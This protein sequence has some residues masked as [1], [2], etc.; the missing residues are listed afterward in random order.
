MDPDTVTL[1]ELW[2]ALKAGEA[3]TIPHHTLK[4]PEPIDWST[5]HNSEFQRNIEIYSGHGLSE[6][7]DPTHPLA[8]EQSLFTNP[9]QTTKTGMSA[10]RAWIQGHELSTIAS[11]DDHRAHPGQPQYGLAAIRSRA[12]TREAIFNGLYKRQ[13]Y[14]TTGARILLDF[15]INNVLMGNHTAVTKRASIH[16]RAVGTDI[17][18]GIEVLRHS[19]NQPGFQIIHQASPAEEVVTLDSDD[20]PPIGSA[21]YYVRL[22]QRGLIRERVAMAWSSPIWVT[23]K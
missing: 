19:D 18:D 17:I 14:A 7:Y 11:S 10:Q 21:I 1:L 8:F 3:L 2:K 4:M 22:W 5:A 9:S 16:V 6:E 20:Q 13:T 15:S 12:L 23:V